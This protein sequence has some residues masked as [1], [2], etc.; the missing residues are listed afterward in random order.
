MIFNFDRAPE[1]QSTKFHEDGKI[2]HKEAESRFEEDIK[3]TAI[4]VEKRFDVLHFRPT[5]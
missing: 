3:S 1:S 2:T 5:G 4:L